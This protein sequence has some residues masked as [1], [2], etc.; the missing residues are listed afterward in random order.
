MSGQKGE[1]MKTTRGF[2]LIEL[3]IVV[4]IIAII[5]AI[6]LPNMLRSRIQTNEASAVQGIR[7]IVSA[8]TTFHAQNERY[9]NVM[10][11]LTTAT[12]PFLNGDWTVAKNGYNFTLA[13]TP[14]NYIVNANPIQLGVQGN[15][16]FYCDASGVI[17]H[18][19]NGVATAASLPIG[20]FP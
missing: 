10:A 20:E 5:A 12:P 3:M 13:G 8:E 1:Q 15:R 16:G 2:T 14:V 4:A 19:F 18:Q 6:A 11:E 17:R 7:A 9:S